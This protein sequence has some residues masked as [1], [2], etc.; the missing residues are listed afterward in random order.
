MDQSSPIPSGPRGPSLFK[1]LSSTLTTVILIS[2]LGITIWLAKAQDASMRNR[3]LIQARMV[4][5]NILPARIHD[6]S[7]SSAVREALQST[8]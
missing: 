3:L 4:A 5:A 1:H 7:G 8:G 2:G 6:L